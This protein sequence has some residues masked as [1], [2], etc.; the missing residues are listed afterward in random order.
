MY[1]KCFV[2]LQINMIVGDDPDYNYDYHLDTQ[3]PELIPTMDLLI[4]NMEKAKKIILQISEK[5]TAKYTITECSLSNF[6]AAEIMIW[7]KVSSSDLILMVA[8]LE[9]VLMAV[10]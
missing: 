7:Q 2:I 1:Q 6:P 3:I 10:V 8:K 4:D 9:R 5:D